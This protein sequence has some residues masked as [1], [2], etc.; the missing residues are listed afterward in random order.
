[1]IEDPTLFDN[2]CSED[3]ADN[4]TKSAAGGSTGRWT[5]EE[6]HL[7]LKG[8]EM[9]GKGWKKIASLIKTRT[10]VQIRTHAQKYFLKLQK[11]R[12]NGGSGDIMMDGKTGYR[13][14]RRRISSKPV[15]LAP[16]LKPYIVPREN[17]VSEL[18]GIGTTNVGGSL[19]GSEM[20]NMTIDNESATLINQIGN[21]TTLE[22]ATA[23][24]IAKY[25][26]AEHGIFNFL[27]PPLNTISDN[28]SSNSNS[29]GSIDGDSGICSGISNVNSSTDNSLNLNSNGNR[30]N[31]TNESTLKVPEW[32][33]QGKGVQSLLKEAE[34]LN[35]L[36]DQGLAVPPKAH[37][38]T[39]SG[40][41]SSSNT[42]PSRNNIPTIASEMILTDN[43]NLVVGD[44]Y[45]EFGASMMQN[46]TN[47]G[48]DSSWINNG[49]SGLSGRENHS[50][51]GFDGF[52][53]FFNTDMS[54]HTNHTKVL[55]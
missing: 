23:K 36:N 37:T 1:M 14:K 30:N 25:E 29:S 49:D 13:R 16:P 46:S 9:H 45:M 15:A 18:L 34:G 39:V 8:L 5:R 17:G 24:Q 43:P 27:S 41:T 19:N 32:Y 48:D 33:K 42:M 22:E 35:W 40:R 38:V 20:G 10:V 4:N 2:H 52:D 6:H 47:N 12:Q 11:A 55:G 31:P 26:E 21:A 51:N 44:V 28:N 53:E 3:E 50:M 54:N 7:F